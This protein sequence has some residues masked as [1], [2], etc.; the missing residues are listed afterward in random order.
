[1]AR[2][3]PLSLPVTMAALFASDIRSSSWVS[4]WLAVQAVAGRDSRT[5]TND[6]APIAT[7]TAAATR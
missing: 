3:M 1:M 5:T 4:G 7:A 2:P 6:S